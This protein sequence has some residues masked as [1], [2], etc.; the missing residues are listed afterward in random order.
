MFRDA[1]DA[2]QHVDLA[3]RAA[4]HIAFQSARPELARRFFLKLPTPLGFQGDVAS[5]TDGDAG[6]PA[7]GGIGREVSAAIDSHTAMG[8]AMA[9]QTGSIYQGQG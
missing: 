3:G 2:V 6:G 1:D 8:L 4:L 9:L 5:A 7:P